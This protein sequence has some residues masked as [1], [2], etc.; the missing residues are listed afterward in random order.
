[1]SR[2]KFL[3]RAWTKVKDL[4]REWD[5]YYNWI[6][7]Y[8]IGGDEIG[9]SKEYG[10][11][12][13]K[14]NLN[15]P[16]YWNAVPAETKPETGGEQVYG[17]ETFANWA[18][19][20]ETA[21]K[22]GRDA[23]NL[24]G[25]GSLTLPDYVKRAILREYNSGSLHGVTTR[26]IKPGSG[27][28]EL[29]AGGWDAREARRAVNSKTRNK[30]LEDLEGTAG[31]AGN[32]FD[33]RQEV[34]GSKFEFEP[35]LSKR[36]P[37]SAESGSHTGLDIKNVFGDIEPSRD[38]EARVVREV[39]R[40]VFGKDHASEPEESYKLVRPLGSPGITKETT[41]QTHF[42]SVDSKYPARTFDSESNQ[43]IRRATVI[44]SWFEKARDTSSVV[45]NKGQVGIQRNTDEVRVMSDWEGGKPKDVYLTNDHPIY[46]FRNNFK[47]LSY[48]ILTQSKV[49]S[50][51]ESMRNRISGSLEKSL[52]VNSTLPREVEGSTADVFYKIRLGKGKNTAYGY[53]GGHV[54]DSLEY[55]TEYEEKL[56]LIP[57]CITTITPDHRVYLNFPAYLENYDDSYNGDWDSVQ[58]VGRAEKFWGYTGF[59]REISISF[60][61]LGRN[62]VELVE[63]YHRLNRLAG[64]T[65]PSYDKSGLFMRGTL[66]SIT[67]GDLLK[68]K[69]GLIKNVKISWEQ[70]IPWETSYVQG[71]GIPAVMDGNNTFRVPYSLNVNLGFTPIE[72]ANVTE[73]FGAYF[74]FNYNKVPEPVRQVQED[75]GKESQSGETKSAHY[76]VEGDM[77]Y[78]VD[79]DGNYLDGGM[80]GS[81]HGITDSPYYNQIDLSEGI[82]FPF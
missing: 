13:Y 81:S 26:E 66:A 75:K 48:P 78:I 65:A 64:A 23:G 19:R 17:T 73:D 8:H 79:S 77:W 29:G 53:P 36:K 44:P 50:D 30:D 2:F 43:Y 28:Y 5:F 51:E 27:P 68:H 76:V 45:P 33:K 7:H 47:R 54:V 3:D 14:S 38:V 24:W 42:G 37:Y 67:I 57:F 39:P 15:D 49:G 60:K 4:A 11:L 10:L 1:M 61:I 18:Q 59:S 72:E 41:S 12:D 69:A 34:E 58:Y 25:I 80:V 31:I 56:G 40:N 46:S 9:I 35:K 22:A 62:S 6:S 21:K 20:A 52:S 70:D 71:S 82:P 55:N 16:E 63:L 32:R 74:A